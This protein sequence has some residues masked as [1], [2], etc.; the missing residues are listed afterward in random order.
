MN[1]TYAFEN[2]LVTMLFV[3]MAVGLLCVLNIIKTLRSNKKEDK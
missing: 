3:S 1:T 2:L